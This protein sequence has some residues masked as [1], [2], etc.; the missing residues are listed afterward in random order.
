LALSYAL[1]GFNG[2]AQTTNVPA[3]AG[4]RSYVIEAAGR[5]EY[6]S[7]ANTNWRSAF[8]GV[9]LRPGDRL[10]T[11]EQ[12]RAALQLS[13]RSVIRLSERTTLEILP[14]RHAEKKRFSVPGGAIYFFD[15]E[16]PADV[17]FDTPLA[18]GAIRGTEFLIQVTEPNSA[19]HLALIDGLVS[20]QTDAGEI[21]MQ[22]GEELRFTPG[23]PPLKSPLLNVS[24]VI[25]WALYY[26]AVLEPAEL[27]LT[28]NN[29]RD[30]GPVLD[31]YRARDLLA[32]LQVWPEN[33]N[34][35]SPGANL[36]HAQLELAVG[37][38]EA[39]N[40]LLLAA[41]GDLPAAL[42]LRRLIAVVR[43]EEIPMG[44]TP[45]AASVLLARSY[46]FQSR[47]DL[48]AALADAREAVKLAPE[49]GF[50]HAR[51]AELEF[52]FGDRRRALAELDR[53][54]A[55]SPRLAPAHALRGFV[56]LD[57]NNV[58]AAQAAFDRAREL[59]SAFGPA[60]LGRGLCLIRERK[61][62][63]ARAAFQAAAALEPQR[64]LFR[65]YLG[66]ASSELSDARAAEKEFNLAKN[67][68]PNDPTAWLY[69]AL[70]LWQENRLNEAIRDL[71]HSA[72]L[73]DNRAVFRSRLLLDQDRSIRS[74]NLAALYDEAGIPDASIHAAQRAVAEDYAN[75]SGHL[76]L[77]NSLQSRES[78]N[79]YDLRLESARQSELLI[80]NLLAPS[81]G[82]NLSQLVS[83][84]EHLR[85]FDPRPFG[86][87]TFTEYASRGDWHQ[88]ATIFGSLDGFS[89]ALDSIYDSVNGQRPNNDVERRQ[90]IGTLKQRVSSE[91]ELYL[92][93]GHLKTESGDVADYYDPGRAIL[94]FRAEEKQEPTLYAGW[95][96]SW[97]PGVHT[98]LLFARLE[99]DLSY[100]NPQPN[101]TFL[102]TTFGSTNIQTAGFFPPFRLDYANRFTLYSGELQ[103]ILETERHSLVLG[104]RWQSG[105]INTRATL[106]QDPVGA[107]FLVFSNSQA[108]ATQLARGSVYAYYSWQVWQPL[109][110]IGGVS[111]D[112]VQFPENAELPPISKTET[113]R[114]Q[115]SPKAGLL[116]APWKGGLLRAAYTKS[117]GGLFFDN[118]VRLEPTQ[119]G[120]FNQ[121]FRSL[122]PE[123]V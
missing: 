82:G 81:G 72:E 6:W 80:A 42:A 23:A 77:A 17:E 75:F 26:P 7:A 92:Q 20:L 55:L 3:L 29:S 45:R 16:K 4:D 89:Y 113:R 106:Q 39:A 102:Q 109:R 94:G 10:R 56:L 86:I 117:L 73:N 25:Q 119:V 96:H 112:Q 99:D 34:L 71:E 31:L 5:V 37:R 57:Q 40:Q 91:D 66:K 84:Q 105:A 108:A 85:F 38:V 2:A 64:A 30:L 21:S 65:D 58:R 95:H 88:A 49:S 120:G 118:S 32:A 74:A 104:G 103:Q 59:D 123:S 114:D 63:E 93:V 107:G 67:L 110:L 15:R 9:A 62:A 115:V 53:A 12:S 69:S 90:F 54:L 18:A 60:W 101:V 70:H 51:R 46:I 68:D 27:A 50:A 13:D 41:P 76:F 83:E 100:T 8:V 122:I 28:P 1:A 35:P 44:Q 43:G 78:A 48:P 33:L 121:A 98:L 36:L 22:R 61:F 111:Y 11:R 116:L 87:S 97:S 52:A 79:R 19:L 47:A 24:A 14:P